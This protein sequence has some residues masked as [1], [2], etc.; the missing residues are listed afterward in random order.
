MALL[1]EIVGWAGGFQILRLTVKK[2][3][4]ATL[5]ATRDELKGRRHESVQVVGRW[6][7]RMVTGYFNYHAVLGNLIRLGGMPSMA[8]SPH[9]SQPA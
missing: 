8:A 1:D 3:M 9:T 5:L 4:R 7:T 2:R 6:L